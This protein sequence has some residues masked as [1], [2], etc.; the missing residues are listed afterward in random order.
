MSMRDTNAKD[1]HVLGIRPSK[2]Q[3]NLGIIIYYLCIHL[4]GCRYCHV[5]EV[6]IDGVWIG[7]WIY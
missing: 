5:D 2:S 1:L 4:F 7:Y 3:F 6:T